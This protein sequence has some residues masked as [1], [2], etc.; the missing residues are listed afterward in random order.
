MVGLGDDGGEEEVSFRGGWSVTRFANGLGSFN[1][2]A[3]Y[4]DICGMLLVR[5]S[6]QC[7]T[8]R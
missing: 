2:I 7:E 3:F 6:Q 4:L 8:L 1:A 5:L